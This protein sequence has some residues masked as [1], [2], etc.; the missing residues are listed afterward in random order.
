MKN[1]SLMYKLNIKTNFWIA[2]FISS[3][4]ITM[5]KNLEQARDENI[6]A[7][8]YQDFLKLKFRLESNKINLPKDIQNY[9]DLVSDIEDLKSKRVDHKERCEKISEE[10]A[11]A[12]MGDVIELL[13][14]S[15]EIEKSALAESRKFLNKNDITEN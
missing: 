7:E 2:F 15:K 14:N 10:L 3:L 9:L 4:G 5:K 13:E 11:N 8:N 12:G 1:N 6:L